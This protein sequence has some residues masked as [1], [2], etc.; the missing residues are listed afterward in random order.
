M[1]NVQINM[2]NCLAVFRRQSDFAHDALVIMDIV[3]FSLR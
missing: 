3:L 1:Y 2:E